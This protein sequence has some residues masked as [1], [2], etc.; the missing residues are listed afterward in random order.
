[1][2]KVLSIYGC[3]DA[4]V[5]FMD[6]GGRLRVYEYERHARV[7]NAMYSE[8]HD[9]HWKEGTNDGVRSSFIER[10][11]VDMGG[12]VEVVLYSMLS[13]NDIE[14][15]R[16]ILGK[17]VQFKFMDG[18]HEYHMVSGYSMSGYN[19]ACVISVDGGG[20]GRSGIEYSKFYIV[21]GGEVVYEDV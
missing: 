6:K 11:K 1:M 7:R 12:C 4:S 2:N 17:D 14:L 10:V 20:P 16:G 13:D 8:R 21:E 5:T 15:M 18:H 19:R 9:V 3:H